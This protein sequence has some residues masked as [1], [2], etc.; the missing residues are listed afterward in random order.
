MATYNVKDQ[1]NAAVKKLKD[2]NLD[3]KKYVN[4]ITLDDKPL[5]LSAVTEKIKNILNEAAEQASGIQN[6]ND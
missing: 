5:D 6:I 1:A 3:L 4:F 2:V